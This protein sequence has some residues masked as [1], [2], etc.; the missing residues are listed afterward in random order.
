MQTTTPTSGGMPARL[1]GPLRRLA[2]GLGVAI[3]ATYRVPWGDDDSTVRVSLA[4]GRALAARWFDGPDGRRTATAVVARAGRFVEAEIPV[5]EPVEARPIPPTGAWVVSPWLD[6]SPGAHRLADPR[7]SASL[8]ASMGSLSHRIARVDPSGLTLDST[9]ADQERLIAA[10]SGW[11]EGAEPWVESIAGHDVAAIG[12]ARSAGP[13]EPWRTATCHGDFVP[14]N[15]LV[16]PGGDIALLDLVDVQLGP[17]IFDLAWWGWI[18][19]FH[20]P[21]AWADAW[22]ALLAGAGIE[23]DRRIDDASAA[24]GRL[25]VIERAATAGTAEVRERWLERLRATAGW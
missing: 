8:A 15:V 18:V 20:H 9:W 22:P 7:A 14:V 3:T 23:R 12:R 5:P 4:D 21:S 13:D 10:V 2:D 19:R 25:R 6:G 11:I 24:I 1:A 16:R 17:R